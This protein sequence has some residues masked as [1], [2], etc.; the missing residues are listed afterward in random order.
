MVSVRW[1]S[2]GG[3]ASVSHPR[4]TC[5][6]ATN[7]HANTIKQTDTPPPH[8]NSFF[9]LFI[10]FKNLFPTVKKHAAESDHLFPFFFFC[11]FFV[12]HS[13]FSSQ[14]KNSQRDLRFEANKHGTLVF[15]S[16]RKSVRGGFTPHLFVNSGFQASKKNPPHF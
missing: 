1:L 6:L 13:P 9:F 2:Q 11:V 12:T 10:Y 16:Q 3:D 4:S 8:T 15:C 7:S 5:P 14:R